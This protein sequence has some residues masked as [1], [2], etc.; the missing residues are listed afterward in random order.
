[1][2][3]VASVGCSAGCSTAAAAGTSTRLGRAIWSQ[4]RSPSVSDLVLVTETRH[5]D[6]E[7]L[8]TGDTGEL[9]LQGHSLP[10]SDVLDALG[11]N[12]ERRDWDSGPDGGQ[13]PAD[14]E[15]LED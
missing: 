9:L 2:R 10:L 6:W 8:Y 12:V 1:M 14:L 4:P 5:G 11:F 15:D 13:L 3:A 7:G